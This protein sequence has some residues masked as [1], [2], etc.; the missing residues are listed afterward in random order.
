[1]RTRAVIGSAFAAFAILAVGWEV[2][3]SSLPPGQTVTAPTSSAPDSGGSTPNSGTTQSRSAGQSGSASP[4]EQNSPSAAPDPG[5]SSGSSNS[6]GAADGSYTGSLERTPWGDVQVGVTISGGH[7]VEVPALHLTDRGGQSVQISN[8]AAP[9]L[10][11]EVLR[12]Q[13]AQ[14]SMVSGATFTSEAY[15]ASLQSALDQAGF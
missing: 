13:S 6:A 5:S 10:R 12:A 14:V 9:I 4:S 7:I 1:M 3:T 8:Y 2:G 11:S 15:L